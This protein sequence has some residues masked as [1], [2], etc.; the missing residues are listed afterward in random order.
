MAT[1]TSTLRGFGSSVSLTVAPTENTAPVHEFRCLYTR[2]QHK[3]VKKWHDG[4]LKFH[5]FN[6]R[7]MVYDDVRVF[8]GDLHYRQEEDFGEGLELRLDRGVLVEV[9]E[10]LGETETDL[11]L[12]LDRQRPEKAP[13]PRRQPAP[14]SS[15]LQSTG[16]SQ[17][18]KSLLEVLGPSQGRLGRARTYHSPYEQ[19]YSSARTDP[20]EPPQ[21][22]PRLSADKENRSDEVREPVRPARPSLPQPMQPSKR[23]PQQ[24]RRDEPPIEFEEVLD[25]SSDEDVGRQPVKPARITSKSKC[26]HKEA[27]AKHPPTSGFSHP[28]QTGLHQSVVP[29]DYTEK[30]KDVRRKSQLASNSLK[31]TTTPA[32]TSH[33]PAPKTARLLLSRHKPRQKLTCIFPISAAPATGADADPGALS[34]VRQRSLDRSPLPQKEAQQSLVDDD[35]QTGGGDDALSDGVPSPRSLT[36]QRQASIDHRDSSPLFMPD[37][38]HAPKSPSSQPAS[39][40][41]EFPISDLEDN[42][43]FQSPGGSDILEE[44]LLRVRS[45]PEHNEETAALTDQCQSTESDNINEPQSPKIAQSRLHIKENVLV[46]P[47]D[48]NCTTTLANRGQQDLTEIS[49]SAHP[50]MV[51]ELGESAESRRPI[52]TEKQADVVDIGERNDPVE[53]KDRNQAANATR[54]AKVAGA[55]V[56]AQPNFH[57]RANMMSPPARH[58]VEDPL[59]VSKQSPV[60]VG[61]TIASNGRPFRRVL[62]ANDAVEDDEATLVPRP[63]VPQSRDH[64]HVLENLSRR[65]TTKHKSPSKVQR[66]ASDTLAL[67]VEARHAPNLAG[68][69][70]KG[71]A[72]PWTVDEAFLLFNFWPAEIEKPAY[73]T[74]KAPQSVSCA[75]PAPFPSN[76]GG[77]TTARQFLRDDVNVL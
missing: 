29:P 20:A 9:G 21:K 49:M 19:R 74:D 46:Q 72:G 31:P 34:P 65:G 56:E 18:P 71:P 23:V 44:V 51:M 67:E 48:Q 41:D 58:P 73:W 16:P 61:Q 33:L 14:L 50:A 53:R 12:I 69:T 43:G 25:L 10:R 36:P 30:D 40:L 75:A 55:E 17:R 59:G 63:I 11:A 2:D 45:T 7:V 22:R 38:S 66:C 68:Q 64:V 60:D 37:E 1:L 6:R 27:L 28:K 3:K 42:D 32:T 26:T 4:S 8:I 35:L 5:T 57:Q 62:S 13:T 54:T 52:E 47:E 77:I 15:R 70:S 24:T 39:F 76:W